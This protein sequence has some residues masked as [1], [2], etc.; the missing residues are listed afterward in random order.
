MEPSSWWLPR[1]RRG[2]KRHRDDCRS[3][4]HRQP[5]EWL[6]VRRSAGQARRRPRA[7]A[8]DR[9]TSPRAAPARGRRPRASPGSAS[10]RWQ[11]RRQRSRAVQRGRQ[12]RRHAHGNNQRGRSDVHGDAGWGLQLRGRARHDSR[13]R[14]E[15]VRRPSASPRRRSARGPQS[16]T[17][18][19]D[20]D[21]GRRQR[22]RQRQ[23]TTRRASEQPG[24][25]AVEPRRSRA[26]PSP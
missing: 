21:Y 23:R 6:L 1:R 15:A 3:D 17:L 8:R 10:R 22:N 2:P 20:H 18:G 25:R 13:V 16:A 11:R 26:E 5:G 24:R 19:M 4:V 7:E 9:S 12:H 14:P